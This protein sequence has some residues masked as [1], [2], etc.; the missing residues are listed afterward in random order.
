MIINF[1]YSINY[2][3]ISSNRDR[4]HASTNIIIIR[5]KDVVNSR[6]YC[7]RVVSPDIDHLIL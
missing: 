6:E 5:H 1:H 2:F 7:S 4:G 3:K